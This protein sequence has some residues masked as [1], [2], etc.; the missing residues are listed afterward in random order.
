MGELLQLTSDSSSGSKE[1]LG[2]GEEG[3]EEPTVILAELVGASHL[4]PEEDADGNEHSEI[5]PYCIVKYDDKI[6]HRSKESSE[7]GL[8]P[9]WTI[10]TRSLFLLKVSTEDLTRKKLTISL[11][12]RR[13]DGPLISSFISD[14]TFLG[15]V[16]LDLATVISHC[17]EKR[18]EVSLDNNMGEDELDSTL[19]L[20]FRLAT[21]ADR[22]FVSCR[23]RVHEDHSS[24]MSKEAKDVMRCILNGEDEETRS[25]RTFMNI[26]EKDETV[27]AGNSLLNSISSF[28]YFK[29][30]TDRDTG[31]H[32]I[33]VKPFPD[34]ARP[35]DTEYLTKTD[36]KME[37]LKP[38]R[39]WTESGSGKLGTLHLEILS[40]HDLPN[41]DTGEAVGNVTDAVSHT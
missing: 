21:E 27:V 37:T 26:T 16:Q 17:D 8:S 25:R 12:N 38:S 7:V 22:M 3:A 5:R 11:Y 19:A 18:F 1:T 23:N 13:R 39:N 34:P 29:G 20:R 33:R 35:D 6:I 4:K 31:I 41:T 40:C 15:Q 28:F 36:I 32:M 9:I 14:A 24:V 2:D 30:Y 10:E